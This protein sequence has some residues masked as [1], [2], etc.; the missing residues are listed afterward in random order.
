MT[1]HEHERRCDDYLNQ[2]PGMDTVA[3]SMYAESFMSGEGKIPHGM[4]ISNVYQKQADEKLKK[5]KEQKQAMVL[6]NIEK[7]KMNKNKKDK[8]Q[9]TYAISSQNKGGNV[10]I[11][12]KNLPQVLKRNPENLLWFIILKT[13]LTS[14]SVCPPKLRSRSR[15]VTNSFEFSMIPML[16]LSLLSNCYNKTS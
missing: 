11:K 10:S 9:K 12:P 16:M 5:K 7:S 13:F 15:P 3:I 2:Q 14:P 6:A 1:I 8:S 4:N